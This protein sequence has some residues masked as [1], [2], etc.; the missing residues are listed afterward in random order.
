MGL[1]TSRHPAKPAAIERARRLLPVGRPLRTRECLP[2]KSGLNRLL[3][4]YGQFEAVADI[5]IKNSYR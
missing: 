3:A 1:N 5:F 2:D 4:A